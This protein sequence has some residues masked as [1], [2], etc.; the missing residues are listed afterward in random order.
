METTTFDNEMPIM[1]IVANMDDLKYYVVGTSNI[2]KYRD[3]CCEILKYY[4]GSVEEICDGC[5]GR[6]MS[7]FKIVPTMILYKGMVNDENE[8]YNTMKVDANVDD[9]KDHVGK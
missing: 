4:A 2:L 7:N 3:G 1:N 6:P 8:R 9:I 5:I